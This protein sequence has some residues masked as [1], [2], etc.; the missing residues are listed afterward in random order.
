M[1]NTKKHLHNTNQINNQLDSLKKLGYNV[2]Q[3]PTKSYDNSFHYHYVCSKN[4][5]EDLEL[6]Y[7]TSLTD[8]K[9]YSEFV[10][11]QLVK[12]Q[13]FHKGYKS[14]NKFYSELKK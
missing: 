8:Y 7:T 2:T 4:G 9:M 11:W 14:F 12:E 10:N 13:T 5:V 3:S 6:Y 1:V